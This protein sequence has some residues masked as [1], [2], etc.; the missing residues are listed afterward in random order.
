MIWRS[1]SRA[2]GTVRSA[3]IQ[4][5]SKSNAAATPKSRSSHQKRTSKNRDNEMTPRR[6]PIQTAPPTA[7]KR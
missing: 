7:M 2:S 4:V 5:P 3:P 1:R 6:H